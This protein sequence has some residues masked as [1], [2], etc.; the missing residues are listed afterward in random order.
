[1]LYNSIKNEYAITHK[2]IKISDRDSKIRMSIII[3]YHIINN[4]IN[5]QPLKASNNSKNKTK[6]VNTK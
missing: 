6:Y 5:S 4:S 3:F 2:P 1:M